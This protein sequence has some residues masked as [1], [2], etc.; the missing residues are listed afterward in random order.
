[1]KI[2]MCTNKHNERYID[3]CI[4]ITAELW[5]NH[6]EI[7]VCSN[8]GNFDYQNKVICKHTEWVPVLAG[9]VN[10][11]VGA[12]RIGANEQVL[13]L[14][15]DHVPHAP[16]DG[17][18]ISQLASYLS[19]HGNTYLNLSGHG[20]DAPVAHLNACAVHLMELHTYSS[21]HPAIW[22]VSHLRKTLAHASE[23]GIKDPWGFETIRLP[24]VRHFTSGSTVWPSAHGGFLWT[25]KVNV[26]AMRHMR[27]GASRKLRRLLLVKL[28]LE[29]PKRVLERL[30][31]LMAV[32]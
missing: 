4:K 24:G 14:L 19:A 27:K 17:G 30:A 3:L 28:L 21:L 12:S 9:C 13:M 2:L 10:Q 31:S 7:I 29:S 8:L 22:S 26:P 16:V 11:L 6:P 18:C 1:M 20:Q 25:G 15:E 23:Q 32:K 5:P